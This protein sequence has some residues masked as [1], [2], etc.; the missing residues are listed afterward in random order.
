MYEDLRKSSTSDPLS[1]DEVSKDLVALQD[2][3]KG[4]VNA[5]SISSASHI[6]SQHFGKYLLGRVAFALPHTDD[7]DFDVRNFNLWSDGNGPIGEWSPESEP[8]GGNVCKT[9]WLDVPCAKKFFKDEM[10]ED[11]WLAEAKILASLNHPNI[12]K[13]ICCNKYETEY[14]IRGAISLR[15]RKWKP[16]LVLLLES[17]KKEGAQ[18]SLFLALDIILQIA[19][20]MCYL[21]DIGIGHRDLKTSNVA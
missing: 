14:S 12:V 13:F 21:H 19:H 7:E 18:L 5:T 15:W 9:T 16:A 3:L 11:E 4:L 10:Q 1:A 8:L 2:R 20:G 6:L 17:L